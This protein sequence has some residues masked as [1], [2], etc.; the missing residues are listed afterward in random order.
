MPSAHRG[1]SGSA[2][3]R[4]NALPPETL[5]FGRFELRLVER[6]LLVD[7]AST[8]LGSRAIDVITVLIE[9]RH[10][11]VTKRELLDLAWPGMIVEEN[12]LTRCPF[13][14]ASCTSSCAGHVRGAVRTVID[15]V[16]HG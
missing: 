5:R 9:N 13:M 14:A 12:N 8:P 6:K 3:G 10:R 4:P 16:R 2:G 7:G 15:E 11:I 1:P